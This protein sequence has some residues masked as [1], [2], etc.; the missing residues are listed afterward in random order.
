MAR[1]LPLYRIPA[2]RW[3]R[4]HR[5]ARVGANSEDLRPS[6]PFYPA[7]EVGTS[8]KAGRDLCVTGSLR[9]PCQDP[10]FDRPEYLWWRNR[11]AY[12]GAGTCAHFQDLL[13]ASRTATQSPGHLSGVDS[14]F[15]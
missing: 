15:H 8:S 10:S 7:D 4:E 13:Y 11:R 5:P 6:N 2:K 12:N 3:R 1:N 9:P 14:A